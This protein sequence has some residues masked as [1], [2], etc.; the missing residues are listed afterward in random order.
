MLRSIRVLLVMLA[1]LLLVACIDGEDDSPSGNQVVDPPATTGVAMTL[2]GTV[3]VGAPVAAVLTIVDRR[4]NT[5]VV[6]SNASG[7]YS[8]NLEGRPGP[9]LIRVVPK[10]SSLAV[11]Y[12]FAS[13]SG[14]ANATPFTTLAL[15]LA[16]GNGLEAAF[17]DWASSAGSW[18]RR[19]LEQAL[20][21][22]NANFDEELSGIAAVDPLRF[23]FFTT[24]FAADSTGIDRFLDGFTVS[25]DLSGDTYVIRDSSGSKIP[26]DRDISTEGYFIGALFIPHEGGTWEF[27]LNT[28]INGDTTSNTFEVPTE[29]VPWREEHLLPTFWPVYD[30]LLRAENLTNC[31]DEPE[32]QCDIRITLT[33]FDR[34]FDVIGGGGVGT[35]VTGAFSVS[36][37]VSGWFDAVGAPRQ[38]INEPVDMSVSWRW[39]RTN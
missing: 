19:D 20:A 3:A 2:E 28:T 5:L 14:V 6:E 30:S 29:V 24:P 35:L 36:W 21:V 39:F 13:G 26:L 31:E 32:V 11:M 8:V 12:S 25:V 16:F 18:D 27:S 22:I 9:F 34:S 33:R 23:D 10:D 1:T 38:T 7:E 4:G 37:L 15:F 17:N